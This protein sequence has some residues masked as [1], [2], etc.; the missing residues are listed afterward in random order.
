V[1]TALRDR[2]DFQGC[3]T[4]RSAIERLVAAPSSSGL[5]FDFDGVL[6]RI[7][8]D[9]QTVQPTA[10]VAH[11]LENLATVVGKIALVSSRNAEFLRD[12]LFG[13]PRLE[14]YGLYGLEHVDERGAVAV[15]PAAQPWIPAV[16]RLV[17]KAVGELPGVHVEDKRLSVGLHYRH[18]PH[19]RASIEDWARRAAHSAGFTVQP[20]RMVVEL[21]PPIRM[22]KG[23][24]VATL[25]ADL[26]TAWFFGDDLGDLPAFAALH[27]RAETDGAFSGLA[28]GVGND[29][30]VA[31]VRQAADVFLDSPDVLVELLRYVGGLACQ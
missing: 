25:S 31:E 13:I 18:A 16:R 29:T 4:L 12:R 11:A 6:S 15:E 28:V 19:L 3:P 24:V 27:R 1:T 7:Q 22:D 20:G 21:K 8:P 30:D 26:R 9:P 14:I 10:G 5:F 17:D 23:S 2:A